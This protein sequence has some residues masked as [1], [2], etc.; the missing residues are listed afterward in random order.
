M[1]NERARPFAAYI[2]ESASRIRFST[3]RTPAR[4]TPEEMTSPM[5]VPVLA[6]PCSRTTGSV[7]ASM[8]RRATSSTLATALHVLKDDDE[9]IAA[10]A[11]NRV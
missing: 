2:A 3:V 6:L 1:R 5:L 9:F 8:I 4:G 10:D 11:G 7:S